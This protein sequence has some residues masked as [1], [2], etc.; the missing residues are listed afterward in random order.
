M[1]GLSEAA[2]Q[3]AGVALLPTPM[4]VLAD[5]FGNNV[6]EGRMAA[7]VSV[8]SV[9]DSGVLGLVAGNYS[10]TARLVLSNTNR[11]NALPLAGILQAP[12]RC[13]RCFCCVMPSPRAV[14]CRAAPRCS[15]CTEQGLCSDGSFGFG[16]LYATRSVNS[17]P[18]SRL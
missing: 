18:D 10:A 16:A 11:T 17:G 2:Q 8:D 9:G 3:V 4:L 13:R 14:P 5:A 15:L 6:P 12:L 7:S 1:S